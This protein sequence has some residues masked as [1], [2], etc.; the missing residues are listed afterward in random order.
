MHTCYAVNRVNFTTSGRSICH[1]HLLLYSSTNYCATLQLVFISS[2]VST[3]SSRL[4]AQDG[5][6]SWYTLPPIAM[7]TVL[8]GSELK[9]FRKAAEHSPGPGWVR[10][11]D[12]TVISLLTTKGVRWPLLALGEPDLAIAIATRVVAQSIELAQPRIQRIK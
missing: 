8:E 9:T 7:S 4:R 11:F 2:T 3:E 6:S 10:H 12:R 5:P 1:S